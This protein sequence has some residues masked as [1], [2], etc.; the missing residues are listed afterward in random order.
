MKCIQF[1]L[2]SRHLPI[3]DRQWPH[4]LCTMLKA[5]EHHLYFLDLLY[6]HCKFFKSYLIVVLPKYFVKLGPLVIE[7]AVVSDQKQVYCRKALE[8]F[9]FTEFSTTTSTLIKMLLS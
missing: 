1:S 8:L 7:L 4:L 2:S 9:N 6:R 5:L 3:C